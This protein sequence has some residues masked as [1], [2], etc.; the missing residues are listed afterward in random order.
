M[1]F[2]SSQDKKPK[3]SVKIKVSLEKS[4]KPLAD[5]RFIRT[6]NQNLDH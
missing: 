4:G 3:G 1:A 5:E 2:K 6:G